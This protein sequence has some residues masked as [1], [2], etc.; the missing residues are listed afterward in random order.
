MGKLEKDPE[1][2]ALIKKMLDAGEM[3]DEGDIS[4]DQ[5]DNLTDAPARKLRTLIYNTPGPGVCSVCG[6]TEVE[7]SPA[8][9]GGRGAG[10]AV[11]LEC[12][13]LRRVPG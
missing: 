13:A 8:T 4:E 12:G 6:S 11:C 10:T 5:Y 3:L 1:A 2:E 7:L 9:D